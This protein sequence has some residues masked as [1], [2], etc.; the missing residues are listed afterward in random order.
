MYD[1][2]KMT[3]AQRREAVE[4][5]RL[6]QRPW[7]SPPHWDF[8]GP[9]QFMISAAIYEHRRIIGISL[10]R[11]TDFEGALL[12]T[13]YAFALSVYAWCLL[14]NHYHL[15]LRTDRLKEL[16]REIGK[17][18]GRTSFKWNGEDNCR[19]RQVWHNC[20]D[21]GIKTHRHFWASVNYIHHNPVH[22]G[23]V[24][25]WQDWPWSSAADF[26]ERVGRERAS[27]IWREFPILDYGKTWDVE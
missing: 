17:L 4:Y 16:R 2:R 25:H 8:Q 1:Y 21:R 14:P 10:H 24:K 9:L 12:D 6:R 13:C 22:H 26:I 5:R 15:L 18:H 19:G 11:M 23:Y 20:L 3:P 27:K 7:H